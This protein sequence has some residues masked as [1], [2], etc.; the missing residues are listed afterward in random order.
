MDELINDEE[1]VKPFARMFNY[2]LIKYGEVINFYFVARIA[3]KKG[4]LKG[5]KLEGEK[6]ILNSDFLKEEGVELEELADTFEGT[7]T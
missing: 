6:A 7:R 5:A 1:L 4:W 3:L 2:T